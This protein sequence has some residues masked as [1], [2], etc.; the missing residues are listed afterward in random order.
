[1]KTPPLLP[2]ETLHRVLRV[3]NINGLSVMAIAGMITLA[4]ASTGNY[5]G[6]AIGLL[7]A[8]SGAFE[9]HG[10]GLLKAGNERGMQWLIGSQPY[11]LV[12]VL[13][14]CAMRLA[15][16]DPA[17]LQQAMTDELRTVI[18]QAGHEEESFL[19][20][21]YFGVY[22]VLAFLTL[23]YQGLMTLYYYRRRSAV[24]AA[25]SEEREE[26]QSFH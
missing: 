23:I 13:V 21:V 18:E 24:E 8:A 4:V 6:A 5:V 3:A 14:Y 11:L 25:L 10:A 9:L 1:M 22:A 20:T 19:R 15:S 2:D 16:Y 7:V 12:V 26:E 17:L